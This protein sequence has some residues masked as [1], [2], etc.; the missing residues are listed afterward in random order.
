[1]PMVT[2][3]LSTQLRFETLKTPHKYK[4]SD[5]SSITFEVSPFES[6]STKLEDFFKG[7]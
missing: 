6:E 2:T 7:M 3:S 4:S 5:L 1:M